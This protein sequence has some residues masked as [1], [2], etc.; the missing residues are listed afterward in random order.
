MSDPERGQ[1][2]ARGLSLQGWTW[3]GPKLLADLSA[4]VMAHVRVTEA[5]S[6]KWRCRP[7]AT[8]CHGTPCPDAFRTPLLRSAQEPVCS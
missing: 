5:W 7:H 8:R 1:P 3:H 2:T 4:M 6:S